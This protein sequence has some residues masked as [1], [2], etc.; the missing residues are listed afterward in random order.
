[1]SA[2]VAAVVP[3]LNRKAALVCCLERL[4]NQTHPL[5]TIFVIDNS[6][7]DDTVGA[8]ATRGWIPSTPGVNEGYTTHSGAPSPRGTRMVL[9]RMANN[10]GSMGGF[11]EGMRRAYAGTHDWIWLVD[12]DSEPAKE[13]LEHLLRR[14]AHGS[15]LGPLALI[16]KESDELSFAV[17]DEVNGKYITS[18]RQ[19]VELNPDGVIVGDTCPFHGCLLI[20]RDVMAA[21]GSIKGEMFHWGG[22]VEYALRAKAHGFGIVTITDAINYHKKYEVESVGVLLG[23]TAELPKGKLGSYCYYRNMAYVVKRYYG[24]RQ[25]AKWLLKYSWVFLVRNRMDVRGYVLYMKATIDGLRG[26]WGKERAFLGSG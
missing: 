11:D 22:E 10:V 1:M 12:D 18:L 2:S 3:T 20:N 9:V 25:L 4:L 8:L 13:C 19:A 5:E 24:N 21:V 15:L 14:E 26:V 23:R 7:S 16:T 6:S 17:W